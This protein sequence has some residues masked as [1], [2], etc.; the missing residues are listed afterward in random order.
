MEI[1]YIPAPRLPLGYIYA[2]HR[3]PASS[4][5][6]DHRCNLH[7][8]SS[9]YHFTFSER[10]NQMSIMHFFLSINFELSIDRLCVV[11]KNRI[12]DKTFELII[13]IR[14]CFLATWIRFVG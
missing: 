2:H 6:I 1:Y 4:A 5:I 7:F 14:V 8:T 12:T 10:G 13:S 11:H 3:A 9:N